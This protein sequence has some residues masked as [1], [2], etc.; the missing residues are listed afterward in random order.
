MHEGGQCQWDR[1]LL[2]RSSQWNISLLH[3]CNP[4]YLL[5]SL[6]ATCQPHHFFAVSGGT[7]SQEDVSDKS[8]PPEH[9]SRYRTKLH[10]VTFAKLYVLL[11]VGQSCN[12]KSQQELIG[13]VQNCYNGNEQTIY[14][15]DNYSSPLQN[16]HKMFGIISK[17][18][19]A[20]NLGKH[21]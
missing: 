11:L 2:Q 15:R 7:D 18:S 5:V 19:L 14:Q 1:Q 3:L 17:R 9:C 6:C 4:Y 10:L 13:T 20:S 16:S 8:H 21:L 12:L